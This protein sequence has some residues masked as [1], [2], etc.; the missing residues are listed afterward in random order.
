MT[1]SPLTHHKPRYSKAFIVSSVC[2]VVPHS[3]DY[4]S[5][6]A[7][8]RDCELRQFFFYDGRAFSMCALWL[9]ASGGRQ[10]L[11]KGWAFSRVSS[12]L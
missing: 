8:T 10:S 11:S 12:T 1:Q 9:F 5:C 7:S 2:E 3:P 6:P 4:C